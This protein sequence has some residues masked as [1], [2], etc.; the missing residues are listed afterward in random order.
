M[1][2]AT[3]NL[4][5]SLAKVSKITTVERFLGLRF[6]NYVIYLYVMFIVQIYGIICEACAWSNVIFFL[7][8]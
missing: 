5:K 6:D 1:Y 3:F 7:G 2:V 4:I 8:M